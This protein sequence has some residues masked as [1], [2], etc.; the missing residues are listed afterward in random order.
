MRTI[1]FLALGLLCIGPVGAQETFYK[2]KTLRIVVGWWGGSR[3]PKKT[4][5]LLLS[6]GAD[7]IVTTLRE[8]CSQLARLTRPPSASRD[9]QEIS[10]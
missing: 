4:R 6:A 9:H 10:S 3:D 8:A 5:K 1:L 7:R 2:D